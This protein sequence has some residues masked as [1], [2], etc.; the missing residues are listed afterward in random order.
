MSWS[1]F[2]P[3]IWVGKELVHASVWFPKIF[4]IANEVE[5]A[6]PTAIAD[7]T[8]VLIDVSELATACVKDGHAGLVAAEQLV[9]AVLA[10]AADKG[11]NIAEDT[12]VYEQFK[13]F[14]AV[15]TTST[16]YSDVLVAVKKLVTD[17]DALGAA[18]IP[19]L[20]QI[21]ADAKA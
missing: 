5:A 6:A 12:V 8:L 2:K 11:A 1:I 13:N 16:N 15:I 7:A 10:A 21:E 14:I 19:V 18:I 9:A 3:F 20:K 4:K 17:Y